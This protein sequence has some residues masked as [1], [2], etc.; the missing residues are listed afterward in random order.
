MANGFKFGLQKVLEIREDKEEESKRKFTQSQREKQITENE[1][2]NLKN[3]YDKY[4]GIKP[5]EDVIYQKIKRNYLMALETGIKT[6]EKEL[7]LK[8]RQVEFRR[9]ELKKDQISRKTV[10]ILK[11]NQ[12]KSYMK[13]QERI[14]QINNDEIALYTYMRNSE[15]G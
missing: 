4:N 5:G 9:D 15:R 10:E 13:E 12:L 3:S 1:L 14:E 8:E 2:N 6:K 7:I 11:D